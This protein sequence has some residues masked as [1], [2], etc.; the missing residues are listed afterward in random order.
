MLI[1]L[2]AQQP[3]SD[4]QPPSHTRVPFIPKLGRLETPLAYVD[5]R[6]GCVCWLHVRSSSSLPPHSSGSVS[7]GLATSSTDE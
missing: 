2:T 1:L 5:G 6:V 3:A 4:V 7:C